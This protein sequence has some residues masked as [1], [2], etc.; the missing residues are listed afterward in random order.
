MSVTVP[1]TRS[2]LAVDGRR[3]TIKLAEMLEISTTILI[4]MDKYAVVHCRQLWPGGLHGFWL[5]FDVVFIAAQQVR[6]G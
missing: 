3:Q 2:R 5:E 1:L 6:E 4:S